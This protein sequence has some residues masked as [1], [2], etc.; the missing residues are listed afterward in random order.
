MAFG[1]TFELEEGAQVR[2]DGFFKRIGTR[3]CDM[4]QRV[5]FAMDAPGLIGKTDGKKTRNK[6]VEPVAAA[7]CDN[8]ND[9]Q[10]LHHALLEFLRVGH[11]RDQPVRLA[12]RAICL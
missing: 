1:M 6:S 10:R 9:C 7:M 2:Q 3:L 8:P 5:S 4:R 11:W 12:G